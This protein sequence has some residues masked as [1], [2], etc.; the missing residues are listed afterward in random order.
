MIHESSTSK[1]WKIHGT[2]DDEFDIPYTSYVYGK[3]CAAGWRRFKIGAPL[4]LRAG[5]DT[6]G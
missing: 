6:R 2:E 5:I 3:T 1:V 4:A